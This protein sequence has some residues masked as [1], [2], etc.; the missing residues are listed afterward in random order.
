MG[1]NTVNFHGGISV[2]GGGSRAQA[3]DLMTQMTT[4]LRGA[5]LKMA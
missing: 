3:T 1:G 4:L 2:N 5:N